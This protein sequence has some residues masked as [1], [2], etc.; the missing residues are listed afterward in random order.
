MP[1]YV[2]A[3]KAFFMFDIIAIETRKLIFLSNNF[4]VFYFKIFEETNSSFQA[5]NPT[6]NI[7]ART[8]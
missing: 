3:C 4:R 1:I 7:I 8:I 2:L 6:L 5:M